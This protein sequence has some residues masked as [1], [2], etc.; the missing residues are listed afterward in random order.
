[1]SWW[2]GSPAEVDAVHEQALALGI[3]AVAPAACTA[4]KVYDKVNDVVRKNV[5]DNVMET[6]GP[7]R[8]ICSVVEA[9]NHCMSRS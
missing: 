2:V 6:L 4:P 1:M 3:A 5:M 9:L 8:A 7:A